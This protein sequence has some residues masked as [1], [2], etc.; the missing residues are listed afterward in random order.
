MNL[1][2]FNKIKDETADADKAAETA[3]QKEFE[4]AWLYSFQVWPVE[5]RVLNVERMTWESRKSLFDLFRMLNSRVEMQLTQDEFIE[6]RSGLLSNGLTL[7]E[8]T[9]VPLFESESVL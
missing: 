8:I 7:K 3:H 4:K 5:E 6:F 1:A 2:Q 9:R